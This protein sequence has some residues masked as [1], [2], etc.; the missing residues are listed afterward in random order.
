VPS[1]RHRVPAG[2]GPI[3]NGIATAQRSE[4]SLR[5]AH[6]APESTRDGMSL[7]DP[8]ECYLG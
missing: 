8:I 7:G 3:S 5:C 2:A 6:V 4:T 1:Y